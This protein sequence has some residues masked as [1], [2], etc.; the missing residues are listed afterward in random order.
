MDFPLLAAHS[1]VTQLFIM[2][3]HPSHLDDLFGF[4]SLINETMLDL[5]R[6]E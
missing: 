4:K 3:P 6:R 2:R 5:V 1:R